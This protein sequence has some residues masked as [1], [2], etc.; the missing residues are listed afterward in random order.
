MI[1][2]GDYVVKPTI[3]P[4]GTSQVW[5]IPEDALKCTTV[6]WEFENEAEL[7]HVMQLGYLLKA[8]PNNHWI[9]LDVPFLPYSRQDK[10]I[11]NETTFARNIIIKILRSVFYSISTMDAH[12]NH[13]D[14][15]SSKPDLKP[16]FAACK[17][18]L[19]CFPDEGASKRGYETFYCDKIIL[20]KDRDQLTG[21]IKG[22][23]FL[24]GVDPK[25]LPNTSI[26]II[27]DICDGGRTF[28]E[29][30]KLLKGAGAKEVCLYTTHGIYSKGTKVLF[31]AG[32]DRLFNR[33]G[34]VTDKY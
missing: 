19:V 3:F 9:S 28:I 16:I 11:S 7:S 22:L 30:C 15:S 26:L 21:E 27:D 33:K 20:D 5:K 6:T 23:K 31:D 32:I 13:Q 12:S 25:E 1:K 17:P 2:L 29:A 34:E 14:V 10:E 8:Q 4:D 24:S 18:D